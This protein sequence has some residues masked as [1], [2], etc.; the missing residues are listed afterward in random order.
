MNKDKFSALEMGI[1]RMVELENEKNS[2]RRNRGLK[3]KLT[4]YRS[5]GGKG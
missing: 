4:F 1:Y 5:G 2:R 3:R